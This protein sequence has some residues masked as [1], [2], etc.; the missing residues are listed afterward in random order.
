M[1][2]GD[3]SNDVPADGVVGVESGGFTCGLRVDGGGERFG[4]CRKGETCCS[5]GAIDTFYCTVVTD[6][7]CPK[8]P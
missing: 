7:G 3:V 5:G 8:V 2:V 1:L 6:G 4:S